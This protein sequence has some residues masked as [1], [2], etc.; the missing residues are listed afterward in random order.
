MSPFQLF[1]DGQ[2][3]RDAQG[4][5]VTLRGINVA[6]D[7]KY[8]RH[9]NLPSHGS[10]NFFDGDNVSFNGRPFSLEE[11]HTHFARLRRWG[12]NTIR[13]IFTWEAIEYAGPKKYD[14]EW[15]EHT[16]GVL[17]LAKEYGFYV[18]MDPHQ[19]VWSRFSGG[20]G[21]PMWTLYA[22]GLNPRK[23]DVTEAALVHNTFPDPENYPKMI[24][25]TNYTR[26][27]CQVIFTLF[28]A[29][30]DFAPKAIL[31]GKNIQDYLQDHF[32]DA[33]SHLA[34]RI[35]E[36][37][38]LQDSVVIGWESMNEPNR[39][40]VGWP[41]LSVIPGEQKL[42][43][44]T[45][46]TAWQAILTG[47]GRA[48][49]IDTWEFGGLG[50][51]KSGSMLVD[52]RGESAW[53][54]A[55]HDDSKYGWARDPNWKLGK[56]IWAQ[57]GIWDPSTDTLLK[58]DY[59]LKHPKTG[60]K[61]DYEGF[62]NTYFMEQYRKFRDAIRAHH[63]D[64]IIFC[65][66]PVLEVPPSV[67]GT[68][69]DDPRM[70]YAPHYYDGVTLM[71]KKWNRLWNVDV[72]GILRGRYLSP[73]F[74]IKVGETAIRNCLRD[75]LAAIR[76]EGIDYMGDHP[77]VLTEFGIPYDMD[78][79]NAYKTG[80]YSSQSSAMDANHFAV[81]GSGMAGYCLWL[82]MTSNT[83]QW[84]D[85]WNGEDLSIYSL[86]DQ[87]LPLP[88]LPLLNKSTSS[89]QKTDSSSQRPS[90]EMSRVSPSNLRETL[91]TPSITSL[92][93]TKNPELTNA[94]GYRAA[95]AYVRPSPITTVGQIKSHGFD[96][97]NTHF[98]LTLTTPN[99]TKEEAPTEIFLPEFH[100]APDNI[101][102]Q[103][104]GGKWELTV[105]DGFDGPLQTLRWWHAEGEQS[106]SVAAIVKRKQALGQAAEGDDGYL[107]QC[108]QNSC[109]V[110]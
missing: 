2:I 41:D 84:G 14:E 20:S 106:L 27:V 98:S 12:Y 89:L 80:N 74:A 90:V 70:V 37:G 99:A 105:A 39:G 58:K 107:E 38:D 88:S 24:W 5:Q 93:S 1:I 30:R 73:A 87:P 18:F 21:A 4:R 32:T 85:Q 9:P 34:K 49:E 15:I 22:C 78:D 16:I 28:F 56:C 35:K 61:L 101:H 26:L 86:D 29:G 23:F 47:S 104:S 83:H 48:C 94:P 66:P 45:S 82:Y 50:P 110:M 17:R 65:Q 69:D 51:Y 72:F 100:F 52:P 62:T 42:Q 31:D 102:V 13:Y 63:T 76:K 67:K 57:H 109:M 8:P 97:R 77:C 92:P 40:L 64:C 95:E 46:P 7:S 75:Q 54:P 55:D 68:P 6:G 53:L 36:A 103:V 11:A 43:K 91:T 10:D 71:T 3:F 44:G 60:K 33:C 25:S 96:L 59:F 79:R 19:D 81:E 108:Q